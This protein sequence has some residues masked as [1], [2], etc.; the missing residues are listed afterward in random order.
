MK[1]GNQLVVGISHP[2]DSSWREIHGVYFKVVSFSSDEPNPLDDQNSKA[3]FLAGIFWLSPKPRGDRVFQLTVSSEGVHD[4]ELTLVRN[5]VN[6]HPEW[7]AEQALQV[8]KA[9]GAHYGPDQKEEFIKAIHF[10]QAERF[11]GKITIR[12]VEF[13]NISSVRSHVISGSLFEWTLLADS[14]FPD[15]SHSQYILEFEPF[16]GRLVSVSALK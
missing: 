1:K 15:G 7:S 13:N 10:D 12:S 14:E 5:S 2:A 4:H 6:T 8:L 3:P 11:L 16:D 9:A